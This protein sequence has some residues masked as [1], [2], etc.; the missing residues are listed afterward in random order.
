MGF[1]QTC[2][3]GVCAPIGRRETSQSLR[4]TDKTAAAASAA[5][6]TFVPSPTSPP[7]PLYLQVQEVQELTICRVWLQVS[8]RREARVSRCA[9]AREEVIDQRT[10]TQKGERAGARDPITRA[11]F[12]GP[13]WSRREPPFQ[14][15]TLAE[16]SGTLD[17]RAEVVRWVSRTF[18]RGQEVHNHIHR[19]PSAALYA[20]TGSRGNWAHGR[21][22]R[23]QSTFLHE[24]YRPPPVLTS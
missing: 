13:F 20:G 12:V 2:P 7:P 9:R 24:R 21:C 17:A 8:F 19:Y 10:L 6:G 11:S 22:V 4:S 16:P 15:R 3:Q 5:A 1:S 23:I 18:D 14:R